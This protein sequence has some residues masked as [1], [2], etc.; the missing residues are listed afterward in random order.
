MDCRKFHKD[1]EDY[2]E[3]GLDFSGRFGM[4]RHAQQCVSC[5]RDLSNALRL[6]RMVHELERAKAPAN[7]ELSILNG[8]GKCREQGLFSGFRKFWIYGFDLPSARKL[9]WVSSCLAVLLIGIFYLYPFL[10]SRTSPESVSAP[11]SVVQEPAKIGKGE[12]PRPVAAITVANASRPLSAEVPKPKV[13]PDPMEEQMLDQEVSDYV[14]FQVVGPD[15]RPVS[16]RWPNK[17]QVRYGQTPE[18][19]F[20]RNVSH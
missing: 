20:I 11:P 7:F 13:K 4:E 8:I 18:E 17:T 3:D 10:S 19:Y 12:N 16:F 15:N 1:L 5:G 2:L 14:E 6:R 9:V